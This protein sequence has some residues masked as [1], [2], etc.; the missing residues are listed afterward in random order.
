MLC[1]IWYLAL[2]VLRLWVHRRSAVIY[3]I[4]Y[5]SLPFTQDATVVLRSYVHVNEY[6]RDGPNLHDFVMMYARLSSG[7]R[8]FQRPCNQSSRFQDRKTVPGTQRVLGVMTGEDCN[9]GIYGPFLED[10][11]Q[12][13]VLQAPPRGHGTVTEIFMT[14]N[15]FCAILAGL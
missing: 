6:Q 2:L 14:I 3:L 7:S 10:Q 13:N 15:V 8:S 1:P 5:R 11:G 9:G 12:V 4:M